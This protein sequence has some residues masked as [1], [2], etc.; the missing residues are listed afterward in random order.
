L[1]KRLNKNIDKLE[2]YVYYIAMQ[3]LN[4]FIL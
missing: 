4:K 3:Q 2:K 1:F